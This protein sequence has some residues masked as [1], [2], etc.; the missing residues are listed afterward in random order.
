MGRPDCQRQRCQ[1]PARPGPRAQAGRDRPAGR[2]GGQTGGRK[3]DQAVHRAEERPRRLVRDQAVGNCRKQRVK[4][5]NPLE[6]SGLRVFMPAEEGPQAAVGAENEQ[7][8]L[9]I[10]ERPGWFPREQR[11]KVEGPG[12]G[13]AGGAAV[14]TLE[15][16][17]VGAQA[18]DH[19]PRV[20]E[21]VGEQKGGNEEGDQRRPAQFLPV[22]LEEGGGGPQ[23]PAAPRE[24]R[25]G[26]HRRD[27]EDKRLLGRVEHA[28]AGGPGQQPV[29]GPVLRPAPGRQREQTQEPDEQHLHDVVAAEEDHHRA[30]RREPGGQHRAGKPAQLAPERE[31]QE[32]QQDAEG[33]RHAPQRPFIEFGEGPLAAQPGHRQGG[34]VQ[35]R[36]VEVP[37][38]VAEGVAFQ[39]AA[40]GDGVHGFVGVHHPRGQVVEAQRGGGHQQGEHGQD[41]GHGKAGERE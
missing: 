1:D 40:D 4:G 12:L 29:P 41:S 11:G 39:Q 14:S 2:P 18:V 24:D 9:R 15:I 34:V 32:H 20:A 25:C 6:M 35:D 5:R 19:A 38:V 10:Q 3:K 37:R 36:A 7:A 13:M 30:E 8:D 33:R 31:G 16:E 22:G 21:P 23:R 17:Q 28:E 27:V 26:H